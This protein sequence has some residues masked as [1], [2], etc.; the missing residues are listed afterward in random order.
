MLEVDV[1]NLLVLINFVQMCQL[2]NAHMEFKSIYKTYVHPSI[3]CPFFSKKMSL[4]LS[5]WKINIVSPFPLIWC[6][7]GKSTD[8]F[9]ILM[10]PGKYEFINN[11]K[12][13]FS[14][15]TTIVLLLKNGHYC[16]CLMYLET[17]NRVVST[18]WGNL[19]FV[20][21]TWTNQ[22]LERR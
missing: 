18:G 13:I 20:I 2:N 19:F 12:G 21:C 10:D 14:S 16:F 11:K 4:K 22:A 7:F 3:N 6:F 8:K 9:I 17:M 1:W 15:N 5:N